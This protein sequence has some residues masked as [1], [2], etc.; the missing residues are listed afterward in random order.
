MRDFR[1]K[2]GARIVGVFW[3]DLD[4]QSAGLLCRDDTRTWA[5]VWYRDDLPEPLWAELRPLASVVI[6]DGAAMSVIH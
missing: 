6:L 2:T 4:T 1:T 5:S 3:V